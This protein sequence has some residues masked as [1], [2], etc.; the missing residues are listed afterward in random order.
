MFACKTGPTMPELRWHLETILLL[1][2][3]I[4]QNNGVSV[5]TTTS[6]YWIA[7]TT[8]TSWTHR[9]GTPHSKKGNLTA[10]WTKHSAVKPSWSGCNAPCIHKSTRQ[11]H[12]PAALNRGSISSTRCMGCCVHLDRAVSRLTTLLPSHWTDYLDIKSPKIL[13][14]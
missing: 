10:C 3:R 5:R 14:D 1:I 11:F 12:V 9:I 4:D 13:Y 2:P 6:S 8:A 7:L